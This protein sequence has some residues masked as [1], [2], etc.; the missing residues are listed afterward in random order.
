M[1]GK[2]VLLENFFNTFIAMAEIYHLPGILTMCYRQVV[3]FS[4][5]VLLMF[6]QPVQLFFYY[7]VSAS[8][9]IYIYIYCKIFFSKNY[10]GGCHQ[11]NFQGIGI[12]SLQACTHFPLCYNLQFDVPLKKMRKCKF[13]SVDETIKFL[14]LP[15][16]ELVDDIDSDGES[17]RANLDIRQTT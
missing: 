6:F 12:F 17:N 5:F 16:E 8:Y 15:E 14:V 10:T 2:P 1:M 3:T 13:L 11:H 9:S 4:T 7:F